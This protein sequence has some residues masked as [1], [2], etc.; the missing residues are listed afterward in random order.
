LKKEG[1]IY[2]L[3]KYGEKEGFE[4]D[5]RYGGD[6]KFGSYF[7]EEALSEALV[8]CGFRVLASTSTDKKV[9]EYRAQNRIFILAE[10]TN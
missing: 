10:K 9:D 7:T 2:V 3:V 6:L 4:R 1:L 8:S 5:E